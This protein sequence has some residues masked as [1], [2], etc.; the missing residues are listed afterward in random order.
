MYRK[1]FDRLNEKAITK[2]CT[3]ISFFKLY[4]NIEEKW[5]AVCIY[6]YVCIYIEMLTVI[7]GGGFWMTCLYMLSCVW[8]FAAPWTVAS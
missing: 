2:Q 8:L 4:L 6:I 7:S 1:M 3:V 5:L